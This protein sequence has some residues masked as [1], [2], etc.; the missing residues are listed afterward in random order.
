M[1]AL[2]DGGG[3]TVGVIPDQN[4]ETLRCHEEIMQNLMQSQQYITSMM[5]VTIFKYA[6]FPIL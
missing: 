3:W 5:Q 2:V 6:I 4:D 1:L